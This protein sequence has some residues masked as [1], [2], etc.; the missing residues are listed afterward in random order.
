MCKA[1]ILA[2][3][4][5]AFYLFPMLEQMLSQEFVMN[6]S[7][8]SLLENGMNFSR[9][10]DDFIFQ[11]LKYDINHPLS[12]SFD[13]GLLTVIFLPFVFITRTDNAR[14]LFI[15]KISVITIICLLFSTNLTPASILKIFGFIQFP[16]RTFTIVSTFSPLIS[17]YCLEKIDNQSIYRSTAVLILLFTITNTITV[18]RQIIN[19]SDQIINSDSSNTIFVE[20]KY[21][22]FANIM[23]YNISEL[24]GGEYLPTTYNFDYKQM[25]SCIA[26]PNYDAAICDYDRY[27]TTIKF[28]SNLEWKEN[29]LLPLTYYKGYEGYE[30]DSEGNIIKQLDLFSEQYSK[31]VAFSSDTGIHHYIIKYQ[32]TMI[33]RISSII[34]VFSIIFVILIVTKRN[35]NQNNYK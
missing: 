12:Y 11:D 13:P 8:G 30:I 32:G 15:K 10:F 22:P 25:G 20:Q 21:K 23:H 27:G 1:T 34:S 33:Q 29:L 6:Q 9:L 14:D 31:R 5:A 17:A 24:G 4:I 16:W 3:L 19:T 18:Y 7:L 35:I 26:Y 28:T 2:V